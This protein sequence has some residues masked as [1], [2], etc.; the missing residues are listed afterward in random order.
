MIDRTE[1]KYTHTG[2]RN[3]YNAFYNGTLIGV[4]RYTPD[5]SGTWTF[6]SI[7]EKVET[8]GSTRFQAV[9]FY[10]EKFMKRGEGNNGKETNVIP[11]GARPD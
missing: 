10:I 4:V 2:Q 9:G 8:F 6:T 5:S 3:T 1:V 11:V 7:R